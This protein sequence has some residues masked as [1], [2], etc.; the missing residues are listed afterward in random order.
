VSADYFTTL[1]V[2][3]E[4]PDVIPLGGLKLVSFK[5]VADLLMVREEYVPQIIENL[6]VPILKLPLPD[7]DPLL[8]KVR[9]EYVSLQAIELAVYAVIR[10]GGDNFD[11]FTSKMSDLVRDKIADPC[12]AISIEAA[13]MSATYSSTARE[14]VEKR[15]Q[16]MI[17]LEQENRLGTTHD[18]SEGG[19]D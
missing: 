18:R 15:L 11:L 4:S 2:P 14:V 5:A 8:N 6:R 10:V 16:A 3:Q 17:R 12:H 1:R 7:T 19:D 9:R 13:L